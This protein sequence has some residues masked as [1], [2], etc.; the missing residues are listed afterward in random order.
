MI[1]VALLSGGD[2]D[3]NGVT[4]FGVR[5]ACEAARAGFGKSL[6]RIS[7]TD[8]AGYT[9]WRERF[10]LEVQTNESKHFKSRHESLKLPK[11]FPK[12]DILE[13]Y[14]NPVISDAHGVA[15]LRE[16]LTGEGEIDIV[17]LRQFVAE[18]FGWKYKVGAKKLIRGLAPVF[19]VHK[20]RLRGN[21]REIG[22]NDPALTDM[23]EI[24]LVRSICGKRA[25][26][27]TDA[28]PEIRVIFHP[29]DI[30][31]LDI[32]AEEDVTHDCRQDGLAPLLEDDA[33]KAYVANNTTARSASP[34]KWVRL[35]YDPMQPERVWIAQIMVKVGVPLKVEDYEESLRNSK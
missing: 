6:C 14:T 26:F 8:A 7:R 18:A 21:R 19:L 35:A 10:N 2:Y 33:A 3:T 24:E 1:L 11:T 9:K 5:I 22:Y 28:L 29:N 34:R 4:G 30:V 32:E 13:Y 17:G 12:L 15:K 27:A 25:H 20:L 23:N 31:G 16:E